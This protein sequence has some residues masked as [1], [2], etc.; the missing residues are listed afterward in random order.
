MSFSR[1]RHCS[2]SDPP[3]PLPLPRQLPLSPEAH[4]HITHVKH[5]RHVR[6]GLATH[7]CSM[8]ATHTICICTALARRLAP[9]LSL[10]SS[11]V[12]P[13]ARAS[14]DFSSRAGARVHAPIPLRGPAITSVGACTRHTPP[15]AGCA[16][17]W[18]PSSCPSPS[19]AGAAVRD[20]SQ[21]SRVTHVRSHPPGLRGRKMGRPEARITAVVAMLTISAATAFAPTPSLTVRLCGPAVARASA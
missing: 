14:F 13:L 15:G 3:D 7:A 11:I 6:M 12:P 18:T 19:R 1:A 16:R 4:T 2:P 21:N 17:P 20:R 10:A 9:S 8:S 5:D